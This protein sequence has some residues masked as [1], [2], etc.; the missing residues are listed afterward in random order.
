MKQQSA[1]TDR[2]NMTR[3]Y[4]FCLAFIL[5]LSFSLSS[6]EL[7]GQ[8]KS[9]PWKYLFDGKDLR[10]FDIT[11]DTAK[12]W[13]EHGEILCHMVSNTD[14]HTFVRT[15]KKY[16]DFILEAECKNEGEFHTGI[17]FRCLEAPDTATV[18]IYGYQMKIDPTSRKWTGGVFDDYGKTWK[19][20]YDLSEN[21]EAREAF[22]MN[23]WNHFRIEAIGPSV[24]VWVNDI[25]ATNMI[26]SKY[27]NGYIA[28]KIHSM[29]NFPEKEKILVHWRN[30][31]IIDRNPDKYTSVSTAKLKIVE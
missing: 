5:S 6:S 21:P 18:S 23:E 3:Y 29:G 10:H 12:A 7:S 22:K 8:E 16:G 17:L 9:A 25:A 1:T 26:N 20:M 4:S 31:R 11:G 19:W 28:L 27:S 15:K 2:Y 13:V 14:Q 30:I 24:K